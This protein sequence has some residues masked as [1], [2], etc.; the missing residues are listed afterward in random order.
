MDKPTPLFD[1]FLLPLNQYEGQEQPTLP[2][3]LC[4]APP[5][6]VPHNRS[7]DLFVALLKMTGNAP[8][9]AAAT[10][11]LLQH[12]ADTY[13][14]HRGSTTTALKA[15]AERINELLFNRNLRHSREGWQAQAVLTLAV[16]RRD[17][18]FIAQA[19][20]GYVYLL[21][22]DNQ[23]VYHDPEAARGAVGVGRSVAVRFFQAQAQAGDI[24][25]LCADPPQ[26]WTAE[27]MAGS[28]RLSLDHLRRRLLIE[29]GANLEAAVLQLLPGSG[30]IRRLKPRPSAATPATFS[31]E[32]APGKA[33]GT[34]PPTSTPT[35][36]PAT[37]PFTAAITLQSSEEQPPQDAPAG[38]QPECTPSEAQPPV[39][40][41][42]AT[43]S[44]PLPPLSTPSAPVAPPRRPGYVPPS[45]FR[46]SRP[47]PH[48]Q[49][50][51]S[52]W[53][54]ASRPA[55]RRIAQ[56]SQTFFARLLPTGAVK[57]GEM[58]PSVLLFIAVAVPLVVVA[59]AVTVYFYAP[60]G[61]NEQHRIYLERALSF[62]AQAAAQDDPALQRN[63][64][65]QTLYWLDQADEFGI[66]NESRLLRRRV[67]ETVDTLDGI[68]RL[69]MQPA[70]SGG[71]GANVQVSQI[72]VT[73]TDIFLLD[74]SEGKVLRLFL[75]A[76]GYEVDPNFQ[77][78][79]GPSGNIQ[80]TPFVGIV[81]LPAGMQP[82]A[83]VLA[84]DRSGNI[85][86][87][88]LNEYPATQSLPVPDVG[89]GE[90]V[91]VALDQDILYIFDRENNRVWMYAQKEGKFKAQPHLYFDIDVPKLDNVID[92]AVNRQEMYLLHDD[93]TMTTC[94]FRSFAAGQT[95]CSDPARYGDTRPGKE[96][97]VQRFPEGR[98]IKMIATQPPDPSLY[99]LDTAGASVYHFSLRLNLQRQLRIEADS[100]FSLPDKPPTAFAITPGPMVLVAYGNQLFAA[101]LP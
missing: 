18:L 26:S 84:V 14:S 2:G 25:V 53:L 43:A 78:G 55:R 87:C 48:W 17:Q 16:L 95:R 30:S 98:F 54:Q 97:E 13:Y 12:A 21:S 7:A 99:I 101:P 66:S 73:T 34:P 69:R 85:A 31:P 74:S 47:Q 57:P 96:V 36:V 19:G 23:Q 100:N 62:A 67:Q 82:T 64:W 52:E 80:I 10:E 92:M 49:R 79:P 11:D 75:T 94:T 40:P 24:V 91:S 22:K 35:P 9:S 3:F 51:I 68:A 83:S 71:L 37:T 88:A 60:G 1:L 4:L 39:A 6:R 38:Q 58:T 8:L 42:V 28:A 93:G 59:V 44:R 15:A 63:I 76:Q 56:A 29:A 89:W 70:L 61:R 77:C 90:I 33:G 45:A 27:V 41:P 20:S 65:A 50:R 72:I 5:R 86:Y 32:S 81:R 46:R